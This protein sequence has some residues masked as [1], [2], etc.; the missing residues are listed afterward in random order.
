VLL[1][2]ECLLFFILLSTQSRNFWIHPCMVTGMIQQYE[3]SYL[4]LQHMG[5]HPGSIAVWQ[6]VTGLE[7]LQKQY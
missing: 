4:F 1:L 2:N 7:H 6:Q 5:S 3:S